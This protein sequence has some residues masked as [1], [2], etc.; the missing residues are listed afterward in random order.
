MA[1]TLTSIALVFQDVHSWKSL[2]QNY[3]WHEDSTI[4]D[5]DLNG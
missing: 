2:R 1:L 3:L 5:S 4:L